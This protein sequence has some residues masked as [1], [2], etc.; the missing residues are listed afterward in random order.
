MIFVQDKKF[1]QNQKS[2]FPYNSLAIMNFSALKIFFVQDKKYFVQ[3]NFGFVLD[4][5]HFVQADGQDNRFT[6]SNLK[7]LTKF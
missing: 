1:C 2:H 3:D 7:V 5:N 4:K 6:L